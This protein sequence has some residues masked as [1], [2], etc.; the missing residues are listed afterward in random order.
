MKLAVSLSLAFL[1][2][3]CLSL[4]S[5]ALDP[6]PPPA[7]YLQMQRWRYQ[8]QPMLV[9]SGGIRWE[10]EGAS[11]TLESGK[12]W[13]SEPA[14]EGAATGLVFEGRG[15]FRMAVPDAVELAQLRRF[16]QKPGLEEIDEPFT[17]LV[18]RTSGDLPVPAPEAP[19]SFK[20]NKLARERHE[21]WLTQWLFDAD[22]RILA[23]LGTP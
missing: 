21:H 1:I 6:P 7:E 11:W 12:T 16:T 2:C 3:P 17:A 10:L 15:R 22:A 5:F 19:G 23:A 14:A 4:P 8:A 13:V 18:L 9:P 20:E